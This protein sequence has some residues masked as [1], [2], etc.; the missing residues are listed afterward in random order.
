MTYPLYLV[1]DAV[2][3][4]LIYFLLDFGFSRTAGVTAATVLSLGLAFLVCITIYNF[5]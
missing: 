3:V 1:H 5:T 4:T 2:G